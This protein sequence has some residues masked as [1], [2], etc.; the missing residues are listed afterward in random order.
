MQG[1]KNP[2]AIPQKCTRRSQ[3]KSELI[4][5]PPPPRMQLRK[6]TVFSLSV[7]PSFHQSINN[8]RF[9]LNNL[10]S[11][12]PILNLHHTLTIR[13]CLFGTRR[14]TEELVLQELCHFVVLAVWCLQY[15]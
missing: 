14:G 3:V 11:F 13:Q 9:L 10:C 15:S 4:I 8:S 2:V 5:P 12:C 7:I 1:D 6:Y